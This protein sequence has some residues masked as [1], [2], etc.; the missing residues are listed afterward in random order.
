MRIFEV[1]PAIDLRGG[2]SEDLLADW[3]F[4][5]QTVKGEDGKEKQIPLF[6]HLKN[7]A[8]GLGYVLSSYRPKIEERLAKL[9]K[10]SFTLGMDK[11][12]PALAEVIHAE[13]TDRAMFPQRGNGPRCLPV[14]KNWSNV[15]CSIQ[16]FF[17][18]QGCTHA[19]DFCSWDPHAW[20]AEARKDGIDVIY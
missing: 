4:M 10:W 12:S 13:A 2:G 3:K 6:V 1:L 5:Q 15:R 11:E 7:G 8:I 20:V 16:F 17:L 19:F 9:V 14:H 18:S